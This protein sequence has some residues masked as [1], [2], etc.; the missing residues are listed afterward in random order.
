[1]S[2]IAFF[3]V[4][5][6]ILSVNSANLWLR[7]EL[8]EGTISRFQMIRASFWV[9]L[10]HLGYVRMEHVIDAAV[11]YLEGKSEREVIERTLRFYEEE[12]A[13][14]V[15]PLAKAAIE[16]HRA[17]GDLVFLLTSSSN[18]LSAP[19]SDLLQVDGFLANRFEVDGGRFTGKAVQPLCFGAGKIAHAQTIADKVGVALDTCAFYTDSISD[20]PLM[21]L[22]KT[23]VAVDPDARLRRA[24]TK[25]GWRIEYWMPNRGPALLSAADGR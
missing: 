12:V 1:M 20:L 23:P 6:T 21:E 7:R 24:A 18:Y 11:A 19:L 3:D 9:G 14:T 10:Y 8:R 16:A 25:R 2:A 22:V 17:Q 13:A 5:K 4:D 15:K